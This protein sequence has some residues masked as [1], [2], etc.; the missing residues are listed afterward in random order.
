MK[1]GISDTSISAPIEIKK[2]AASLI[3]V[4]ITLATLAL[5]DSA[6]KTPAKNA[7]VATESPSRLAPKD[8]PTD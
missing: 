7:P 2:T 6:T 8:N 5:L 4:V 1:M 3:G